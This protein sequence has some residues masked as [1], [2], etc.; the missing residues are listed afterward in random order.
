MKKYFIIAAAAF[1]AIAACTK[2]DTFETKVDAPISFS[3]INHL[4]QTRAT[5]GLT[6][7]T[8]VP[9][10]SF[11]WWTENDWTGAAADQDF[12]FMDN[13]K[14]QYYAATQSEAAKW[15]PTS[16]YYWTKS[17]KLT[18]A[19]YSPYVDDNTKASKGFSA[20]PVYNAAT[21]FNFAD[22][23]I[24]ADTN[25]DLMYAN[26][27][28]NCTQDTNVNGGDVTDSSNPEGGFKGVPTIFNH[29]LCQLG[30]EFR[31]IGNK[32]PNVTKIEI[33]LTDV[34]IM[35]IDNKG[36]FIQL[37]ATETTPRWT[38]NHA[39]DKT[40]YEYAPSATI[41][42]PLIE[43]NATNIPKTDNYT[44][45]GRTRILMPQALVVT[46]DAENKPLDI[47]LTTVTDQK[48]VVKYTIKTEYASKP[49]EWAT[50]DV[51]SIVRLNNGSIAAW[52]ENQN[53]TYRISI[54]PYATLPITFDPAVV[55][56]TDVYSDNID[57]IPGN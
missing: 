8:D 56:W 19:S 38:T 30:F 24:V 3:V 49:G 52:K 9:F 51:T 15:A 17:G 32:N 23:S 46:K 35:N 54:N 1:M 31:A 28:A 40:D 57:I 18:F 41:T 11:A 16:T 21:G 47:A 53:I 29:A 10:G 34:D 36:S 37:P 7:P 5:A 2:V 50:E 55:S 26:L 39:T 13:Q 44:A 43:A 6:Y 22:Y 48:L 4:H 27:A 20:I 45:L 14:V 25:V 33:D 12:V 42:L